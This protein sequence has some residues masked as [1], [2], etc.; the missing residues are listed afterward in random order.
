M[1]KVIL[2]VNTG[3]PDDPGKRSVRKYLSEFL[4]DPMV[5]TMP[6]FIRKYLVNGIIVPFRAGHSSKLYYNLWTNEGSPLRYIMERLVQKIQLYVGNEYKVIGAMRYGNPSLEKAVSDMKDSVKNLTIL[7]LYPQYT[8]STTGSVISLVNRI[9]ENWEKKPSVRFIKQFYSKS[10]FIEVYCEIIL[11]YD[12]GSFDHVVFSY[13]SLPLSHLEKIHKGI[14]PIDCD[15]HSALPDH[16]AL[17]YKATCYETT[18]LLSSGLKL[19]PG[20]FSTAFQSRFYGNWLGPFTDKLLMKLIKENKKRI[21]IAAPS[22]TI[23]CL[24]T[25]VEINDGYRKMFAKAGGELV[26]V[27]SL[28]D[29]DKWIKALTEIINA[30]N[31]K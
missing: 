20:S 10:A 7:P 21:L 22:F 15:C 13:H 19:N 5:M 17:C 6:P 11:K 25:I 12:P 29:N 30:G 16:G 1:E 8:F 23:D 2:I 9:I 18:R 4:N 24:E 27:E 26:M 28:N 31:N 3:T 14:K